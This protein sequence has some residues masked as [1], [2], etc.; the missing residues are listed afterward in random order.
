MTEDN[1]E[2][3]CRECI[4]PQELCE[5]LQIILDSV[6]ALIFYKDR[7]NRFLRVNRAFCDIMGT[8]REELEGRAM[9]DIYSPEQAEAFWKDDLEVIG[10][11]RP[12]RNIV[13]PMDSKGRTLWLQT[14][15][16]PYRDSRGNIIGIIG[17]SLDITAR[18]KAEDALRAAYAEEQQMRRGQEQLVEQLK[19]AL[20]KIRTLDSLLPICAVCKKIRD[21]KGEWQFMENYISERT[22]AQFTH[23]YC[24]ECAEKLRKD[25]RSR[26][27]VC[28]MCGNSLTMLRYVDGDKHFR[29]YTCE[30]CGYSKEY[31]RSAIT[32]PE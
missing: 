31:V 8:T 11:G 20:E 19:A 17:F 13:E 16:I 9:I 12:K 5:E 30:K 28:E 22:A 25:I 3:S 2:L 29:R 6:P 15:K 7:D 14:D 4:N 26:P 24:P 18:K 1:G 21:E 23:G 27:A 10:S 32:G